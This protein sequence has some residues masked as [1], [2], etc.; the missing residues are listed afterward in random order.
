M[1]EA[2]GGNGGT[3]VNV[4][5]SV[6]VGMAVTTVGVH[7]GGRVTGAAVGGCTMTLGPHEAESS[8]NSAPSRNVGDLLGDVALAMTRV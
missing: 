7:V 5:T 1:G 4:G 3:A 6:K 2:S 8:S